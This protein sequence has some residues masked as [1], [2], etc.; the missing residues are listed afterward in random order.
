ML[1]VILVLFAR[2]FF[3]FQVH[4]SNACEDCCSGGKKL[5]E[6]APPRSHTRFFP[7]ES[8][9]SLLHKFIGVDLSWGPGYAPLAKVGKTGEALKPHSGLPQQ[10]QAAKKIGQTAIESDLG[11]SYCYSAALPVNC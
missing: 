7:R 6:L 4:W 11:F 1:E 5:F 9:S 2:K 3:V 10:R 8:R